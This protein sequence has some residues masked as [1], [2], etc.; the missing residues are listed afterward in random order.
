MPP[1][2][3]TSRSKAAKVAEASSLS[4]TQNQKQDA[5]ATLSSAP[6][7]RNI[8]AQGNDQGSRPT[9]NPSP[10]PELSG[11]RLTGHPG[12]PEGV[13]NGN[14]RAGQGAASCETGEQLLECLLKLREHAHQ[15]PGKYHPPVEPDLSD[16]PELPD[17]WTWASPSQLSSAARHALSIGPF[18]SNLKVSD[19]Q[20]EGVPLVFV[21][22]I[23]SEVYTDGTKFVSESKAKEL[24]SHTVDPGDILVTKM[25]EPPGDSSIYPIGAPHAVITADCI[26]WRVAPDLNPRFFMYAL[27]AETTKR[28]IATRTRGVAQKKISLE[29]FRDLALPLPPLPEQRRI[30]SRIEELFSR[31]EAGVAALR[32]AK[33]QLQRYRQS[34]LAAA[35][36]GQLT[37]EWREQHPDTEPAADLIARTE[38]PPRPNRYKSRSKAIQQGHPA[39]SVGNPGTSLPKG[40]AWAH[41]VEIARMESG[42]TPSRNHPEWWDGD[43]PWIGIADAREHHGK[44]INETFQHTN[45]EG[46]ANSASRLLPAG[47]VCISRTASVGYVTVMGC[48]MATSQ[49]FVNWI[50]TKAVTSEWLRLVFQADTEGLRSFGSGSVHKTIYFPEWL[51]MHAAIPPLAEQHQIVAEVEARTTAIDHL[52]AELDRQI[53]RSNRLR[54]STLQTAFAGQL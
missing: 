17:H 4:S 38:A 26:K 31:I 44:V 50:P 33:A 40:W 28:Q 22:N 16:L 43:I 11:D 35:V 52:E 13:T 12:S 8:P 49:D 1:R 5:S 7:G 23:R 6:K 21:R 9:T 47:T 32:H 54:Q 20:D 10:E 29:R 25:G 15:G 3:T 46:L 53:T 36:T 14:Q 42:H 2:R 51:S 19:Y 27:R 30:V 24:A 34:V 45:Q 48:A 37:Q 41:L 39:L 18:G